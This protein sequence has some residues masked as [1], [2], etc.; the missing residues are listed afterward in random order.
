MLSCLLN[1]QRINCYDGAYSRDQLKKWASK[2]ILL[3]PA[4]GKPYEYCH[5]KV[6]SP[7]F[8]HM[9]KAQCEDKY[10]EPETEEHINGKRDLYEWIRIQPGVEDAVLEGWI[11]ET[12]QRP[13]IMFK[14][15]G[16]KYVLEYQCTP[17][18]T[19][20]YERHE[21]YQA[22]G[23]ND[24]WILGTEKYLRKS[25]RMKSIMNYGCWLYNSYTK[26]MCQLIDKHCNFEE[27]LKYISDD[28]RKLLKDISRN[29][30][31]VNKNLNYKEYK[32]GELCIS[33]DGICIP[34]NINYGCLYNKLMDENMINKTNIKSIDFSLILKRLQDNLEDN[35]FV[36]TEYD[37][38]IDRDYSSWYWN[39]EDYKSI[40]N[41][42]YQIDIDDHRFKIKII[43]N[44]D[45][46]RNYDVYTEEHI[47]R[48]I[49]KKISKKI[50]KFSDATLNL[51]KEIINYYDNITFNK[52]FMFYV[53]YNIDSNFEMTLH[54]T[55][56]DYSLY[57][58]VFSVV[59]DNF[60]NMSEIKEKIQNNFDDFINENEDKGFR[61]IKIN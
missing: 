54:F 14:Y 3:C 29:T 40:I 52:S 33:N 37:E 59:I 60:E 11:P 10:S 42:Y 55:K 53:K 43:Q 31:C 27:D 22:A 30:I 32:L 61:L 5:G 9:D 2:K 44:F 18:S 4:C 16:N 36:T 48:Y 25:M 26:R 8:R 35:V 45:L 23:I 50:S 56:K 49:Y 39:R 47:Y 24:I 12:K 34:E 28:K 58:N 38:R 19:E 57:Y 20:Y 15:M 17:I 7:Y 41:V 13:D 6:K 51:Y 21:L 1:N 46:K